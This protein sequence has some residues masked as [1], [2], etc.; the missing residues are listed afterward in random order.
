MVQQRW[1]GGFHLPGHFYQSI[2]LQETPLCSTEMAMLEKKKK[3]GLVV[4]I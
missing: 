2:G 4:F 1:P 3:S